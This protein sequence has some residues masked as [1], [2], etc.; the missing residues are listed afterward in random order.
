M[1]KNK[2]S[3]KS[4]GYALEIHYEDREFVIEV[5]EA[6]YEVR[7]LVRLSSKTRSIRV[8][9]SD[10]ENLIMAVDVI[11]NCELKRRKWKKW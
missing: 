4:L 3:N 10:I 9:A 6:L 5:M 11:E 1:A 2:L 7:E 8:L